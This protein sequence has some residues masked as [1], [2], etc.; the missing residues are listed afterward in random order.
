[1]S[2]LT[3]LAPGQKEKTCPQCGRTFYA[4][5][6]EE[7]RGYGTFCGSLCARNGRELV[8]VEERF[9]KLAGAPITKVNHDGRIYEMKD[10]N[11]CWL[12]TG[13][14]TGG[15]WPYGVLG[16]GRSKKLLKAHHVSWEIHCGPVLPGY[17]ICHKC[18]TTLCVNP[19]HLFMGT[20]KTNSEDMSAKGRARGG[21]PKG[22]KLSPQSLASFRQK[23]GFNNA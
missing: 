23:R 8:P 7:R 21:R 15:K 22:S 13:A 5:P 11:T 1:M 14:N 9:W 19:D 6:S 3:R 17:C 4:W 18:D 20:L 2:S 12:W 16:N 10:P